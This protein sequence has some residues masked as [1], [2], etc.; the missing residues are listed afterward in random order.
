MREFYRARSA[1]RSDGPCSRLREIPGWVRTEP[2]HDRNVSM[3]TED[4]QATTQTAASHSDRP[5]FEAVRALRQ[6][7]RYAYMPVLH[8]TIDLGPYAE[9]SSET[10][11]GFVDRLRAWLPGIDQHEC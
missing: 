5:V 4:P 1:D 2:T 9:A 10:F 7:N 3:P 11:P 6:H 8:A